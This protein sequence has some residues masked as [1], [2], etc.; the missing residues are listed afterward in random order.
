MDFGDSEL[1]SIKFFLKSWVFYQLIGFAYS[2]EFSLYFWEWFCM[3]NM[4]LSWSKTS[5]WTNKCTRKIGAISWKSISEY[6]YLCAR[7]FR[8][9][10]HRQAWSDLPVRKES[11]FT[12]CWLSRRRWTG[13]SWRLY[14]DQ[15][16]EKTTSCKSSH[17]W[18]MRY[19]CGKF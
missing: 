3:M 4:N 14:P 6:W 18:Q 9:T 13:K 19:I 10:S 5:R 12:D 8:L 16:N 2:G 7:F 15:E 1:D 17:T 11:S